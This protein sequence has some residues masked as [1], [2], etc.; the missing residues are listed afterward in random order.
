M[1]QKKESFGRGNTG[2]LEQI[3]K[4]IQNVRI[5]HVRNVF[6]VQFRAKT[7]ALYFIGEDN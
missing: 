1:P 7:S 2:D 4:N 5:P 6:R 3:L